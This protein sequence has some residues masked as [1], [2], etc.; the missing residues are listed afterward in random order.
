MIWFLEF[1]LHN[2]TATLRPP[3]V[4]ETLPPVHRNQRLR[5]DAVIGRTRFQGYGTDLFRVDATGDV[6]LSHNGNDD[7]DSIAFSRSDPTVMYLG[8]ETEKGVN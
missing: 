3:D 7:V 1:S 2:R 4:S 6:R 8:L 5:C